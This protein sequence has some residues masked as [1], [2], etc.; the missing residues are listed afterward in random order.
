MSDGRKTEEESKSSRCRAVII[1]SLIHTRQFSTPTT[2]FRGSEQTCLKP[3]NIFIQIITIL[4][5]P[6]IIKMSSFFSYIIKNSCFTSPDKKH[7]TYISARQPSP[8]LDA[9]S[10]VKLKNID[11]PT[12]HRFHIAAQKHT[13]PYIY[14]ITENQASCTF[15]ILPYNYHNHLS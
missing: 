6:K 14:S 2:I 4:S 13:K 7:E 11:L 1:T 5:I 10:D 15:H 9:R 3:Q 12:T 8:N